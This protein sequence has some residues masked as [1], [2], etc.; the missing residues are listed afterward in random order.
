MTSYPDA[1]D[2]LIDYLQPIVGVP[3]RTRVPRTRPDV[4]LHVRRSGG[5]DDVVR[6]RPRLDVFAWA[7]DD[8]ATRDLLTTARSAIHDLKGTTLLGVTCY[9]VEEFLGPTR[10]DDRETGTP[11]MWMTVQLSLRTTS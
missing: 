7:P 6:D 5:V 3:V 11:R 1:E 10:A 9:Q 2:L 4:W 8:G